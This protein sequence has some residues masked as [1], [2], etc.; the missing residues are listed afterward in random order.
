MGIF[1]FLFG[2]KYPTTKKYEA[3]QQ[4]HVDDFERFNEYTKSS[5]LAR[6][7]ELQAL[8]NTTEFKQKVTKLKEEKFS[9]TEAYKKQQEYIKLKSS[10]DIVD[11]N[12]FIN[13]KYDSKLE[14]YLESYN[15]TRYIELEATI[16]TPEFR[17]AMAQPSKIWKKSEEFQ[18]YKEYQKLS[19][20]NEVKFIKKTTAS[21]I[22]QNYKK[23]KD[24]DKLKKYQELDEYINSNEF[25]SYKKEI[26]DPKRFKKSEECRLINEYNSLSKN[27]DLILYQD[28]LK[29]DAFADIKKWKLT[30]EDN[31]DGNKLDTNKW[32]VGYYWGNING[33]GIYSPENEK[34]IFSA[35]NI[36]VLNSEISLVTR[37]EKAQGKVWNTKIGFVQGEF[38]YTSALINTGN[39]FRQQ[40]GRFDFKVKL[41]L[42]KPVT[43]N[44]WMVGEK[45]EPQINILSFGQ[46]KNSINVGLS[47]KNG[48]KTIKIDGA[49]F[50]KNY[51]IVSL[52][53]TPEKLVWY[54]NGVESYTYKGTIPQEM[55]YIVISSN[56][57]TQGNTNGSQ[58]CLDWVKCY[59]W[60]K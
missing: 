45:S 47:T 12:K 6:Y 33:V 20:S 53:W 19:K 38:D 44:I 13:K 24:S 56:I 57:T 46:N 59:T 55:M 60:S 30:F 58:L 34:Q 36:N 31:F 26:E 10:T 23:V 43:H 18:Q 41:S 48:S 15:Y 16:K 51:Y 22:Y 54:I 3:Q 28:K 4:Q 25:I 32:M 52:M 39:S 21:A 42:D 14:S 8:I 11:Y 35:N 17:K 40:Y 2:G 50:D 37:K 7:N 1:S 29:T 9:S 49:K 5:D 27:K